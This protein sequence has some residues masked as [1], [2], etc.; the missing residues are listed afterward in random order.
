[1]RICAVATFGSAASESLELRGDGARRRGVEREEQRLRRRR[2]GHEAGELRAQVGDLAA[3][4]HF[5]DHAAAALGELRAKGRDRTLRA[6]VAAGDDQ[7]LAQAAVG[8]AVGGEAPSSSGSSAKLALPFGAGLLPRLRAM[9]GSAPA[10]PST[11]FTS[12]RVSGPTIICAS[13]AI[14]FGQRGLRAGGAA[15]AVVEAQH[16]TLARFRVVGGEEAVA[17]ALPGARER[18]AHGQ[19]APPGAPAVR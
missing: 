10:P 5:A 18:A 19:Q 4:R 6:V 8:D 17:H 2:A 15:G 11:A 16:R 3:D 12:S 14:A 9:V 13:S 1:L 7:H